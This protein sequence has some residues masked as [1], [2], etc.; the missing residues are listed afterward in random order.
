MCA[1]VHVCVCACAYVCVHV[2]V[3]V[4]VHVLCSGGT[5]VRACLTCDMLQTAANSFTTVVT[6]KVVGSWTE[7][8]RKTSTEKKVCKLQSWLL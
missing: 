6:T 4:C 3:C 1:C 8:L 7:S 5:Y 2:H